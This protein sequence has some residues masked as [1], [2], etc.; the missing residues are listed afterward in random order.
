VADS[1]EIRP[2]PILRSQFHGLIRRMNLRQLIQPDPD[3][4]DAPTPQRVVSVALTAC[5]GL[6][7]YGFT[8]GFWRDPVMGRYVAVKLPLLVA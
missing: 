8:V 3:W 5:A 2:I 4:L 6:A 1:W 7:I